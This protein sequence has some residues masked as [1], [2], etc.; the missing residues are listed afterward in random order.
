MIMGDGSRK[1]SSSN[2]RGLRQAAGAGV[3]HRRRT[4][5]VSNIVP[6]SSASS[7]PRQDRAPLPQDHE[8]QIVLFT[9]V[10]IVRSRRQG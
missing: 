10:Q 5:P 2:R 6:F 3:R 1:P 9:G 8:A 7:R 4:E